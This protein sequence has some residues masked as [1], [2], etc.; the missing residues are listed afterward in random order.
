[1]NLMFVRACNFVRRHQMTQTT[2][3]FSLVTGKGFF[4]IYSTVSNHSFIVVRMKKTTRIYCV[5]IV[6]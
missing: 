2:F 4:K 3:I 5:D 1:M 6:L